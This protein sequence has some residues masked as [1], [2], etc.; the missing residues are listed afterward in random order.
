MMRIY[1]EALVQM[2]RQ[3]TEAEQDELIRRLEAQRFP[4]RPLQILRVFHVDNRPEGMTLRRE[5]EY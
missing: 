2:A 5:N 3:L 1:V 4:Q